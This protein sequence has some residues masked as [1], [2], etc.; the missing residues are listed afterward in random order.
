MSL[1]TIKKQLKDA[2]INATVRY[3]GHEI[4]AKGYG[5]HDSTC[6]YE[7]TF[8]KIEGEDYYDEPIEIIGDGDAYCAIE[9]Y[10]EDIQ[11]VNT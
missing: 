4:R 3:L 2:G 5:I 10:L 6:M 8:P 7:I 9:N 1:K 11:K